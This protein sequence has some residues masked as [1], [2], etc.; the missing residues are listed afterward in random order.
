[1][2]FS[3]KHNVLWNMIDPGDPYD[4]KKSLIAKLPGDKKMYMGDHLELI[5]LF[6]GAEIER[7]IENLNEYQ[8]KYKEVKK[9]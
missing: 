9:I 4:I 2:S 5:V 1:M 6:Q 7:L 3:E 8:I